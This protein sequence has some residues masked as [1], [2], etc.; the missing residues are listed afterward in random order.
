[1]CHKDRVTGLPKR[2]RPLAWVARRHESL[3]PLMSGGVGA[4]DIANVP[5]ASPRRIFFGLPVSG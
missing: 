5:F 3:T 4:T 1:M 2:L